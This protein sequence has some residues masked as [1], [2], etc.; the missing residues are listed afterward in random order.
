MR[1]YPSPVY[2]FRPR[3]PYT[4]LHHPHMNW[5]LP[6]VSFRK[7]L[8][9]SWT[10]LSFPKAMGGWCFLLMFWSI[11]P[12][13]TGPS[14]PLDTLLQRSTPMKL[15]VIVWTPWSISLL[16][17]R[18]AWRSSQMGYRWHK[19][20]GLELRMI[21]RCPTSPCPFHRLNPR[22]VQD[23]ICL[24][25]LLGLHGST[26]GI[27][28]LLFG[29]TSCWLVWRTEFDTMYAGMMCDLKVWICILTGGVVSWKC[30]YVSWQVVWCLEMPICVLKV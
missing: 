3:H 6:N 10:S 18:M 1:P 11:C 22:Y 30:G 13:W 28:W 27:L 23:A 21:A 8:Q 4:H 17:T 24:L 26:F 15:S 5:K 19:T 29:S 2:Q 20:P 25:F 9:V 16:S 7:P 12:T 14:S